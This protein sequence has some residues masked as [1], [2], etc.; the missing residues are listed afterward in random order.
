ME[1]TKKEKEP[2]KNTY[3]FDKYYNKKEKKD[4]LHNLGCTCYINSFIQILIHV[5]GLIGKLNSHKNNIH[6]DSLLYSLLNIAEQPSKENLRCLNKK[7]IK[8]FPNYKN[9][10]QEDSQEFGT[11]L[12]KVLNDELSSLNNYVDSWNIEDKFK[13][14]NNYDNISKIKIDKL[15]DLM[16]KEDYN[17]KFQTII[18]SFF[19]YYET[20]LIICDKKLINFSYYGDVDNQ[21]AFNRNFNNK[22]YLN[23]IDMLDKKYL[24]GK[25]KFIKLPI[26]FNITLLRGII[27]EQLI[28]TRVSIKK[29]IDL[30]EYIDKDFGEYSS[31]TEYTLYALNVCFGSNK[32]YGHYY[33]YILINE[34]WYKFD[35]LNVEK[36]EQEIIDND[37]SYIYGIYYIKKEHLKPFLLVNNDDN[38]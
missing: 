35:D 18:N 12:L 33:S 13:L 20:I 3:I 32:K 19:F 31:S 11:E 29:E 5:P 1:N 14:K 7:V 27:G 22:D 10:K 2:I 21:L 34:E 23:I 15:N 37:L 26:V 4:G 6:K 17:F 30:K 9:Y 28:K 8:I 38:K 16:K 36:V 25:N 24:Y